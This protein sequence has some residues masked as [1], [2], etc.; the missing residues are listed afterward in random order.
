MNFSAQTITIVLM[1]GG[2]TTPVLDTSQMQ[3]RIDGAD[4]IDGANVMQEWLS[5]NAFRGVQGFSLGYFSH[6]V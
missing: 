5:E 4:E 2:N 1:S 6:S 3:E